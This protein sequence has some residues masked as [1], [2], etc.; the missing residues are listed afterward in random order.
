MTAPAHPFAGNDGL[1]IGRGALRQL[2]TSLLTHAPD[3]AIT[4]LQEAGYAS[5]EGVY[6]AFCEWLP[7]HAGVERPEDLDAA[8]FSDTLAAFFQATGWGSLTVA[9]LGTG[10]L[11]VDSADWVEAEPGTAQMPMCFFSSGMLADF[12]GRISGET[13]AA[14]EVECR[15]R[16]D[17]RCRFLTATP[18]V[19]QRVYD[20][21]TQGRTYLEALRA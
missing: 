19:L 15:S 1:A 17:A 14:M 6:R 13:M 18:A 3:Q 4:I 20:E 21:M 2:H 16:A 12:L 9:P 11:A 7:A 10:A 5:G 8:E